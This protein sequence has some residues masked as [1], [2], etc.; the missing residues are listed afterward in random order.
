MMSAGGSWSWNRMAPSWRAGPDLAGRLR[1]AARNSSRIYR[2]SPG[3]SSRARRWDGRDAACPGGSR[4][5]GTE[6]NFEL[7]RKFVHPT[8]RV[9]YDVQGFAVAPNDPDLGTGHPWTF[10]LTDVATRTYAF[11]ADTSHD[12]YRSTTMTP[13]DALLTE[14][15]YR[16]IEFLRETA[17]DATFASILADFRREYCVDSRLD[18][19]E[20]IVEASSVLGQIAQSVSSN[21]P[22]AR[23]RACTVS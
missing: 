20:I 17:P 15:S 19:G 21:L 10:K 2:Q 4:R 5:A 12:L 22:Q 14:L 7:T 6:T 18:A 16:T 23:G 9:E 13:L 8:Y 1:D 3:R 11:L